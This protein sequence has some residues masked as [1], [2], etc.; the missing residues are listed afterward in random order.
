MERVTQ[1]LQRNQVF[2]SAC[3]AEENRLILPSLEEAVLCVCSSWYIIHNWGFGQDVLEKQS[4]TVDTI[5]ICFTAWPL[6]INSPPA[7]DIKTTPNL[8]MMHLGTK[9]CHT[10]RKEIRFLWNTKRIYQRKS[11]R[12]KF[13]LLFM[14][15]LPSAL[16]SHSLCR[17]FKLIHYIRIIL[18]IR[19][20]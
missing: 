8:P 12:L 3:I 7:H 18:S 5:I 19:K 16:K 20:N 6:L 9:H 15:N 2:A 17:I 11:H 13:R 10:R 1:E 4:E 14:E